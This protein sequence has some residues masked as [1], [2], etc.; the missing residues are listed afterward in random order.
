MPKGTGLERLAALSGISLQ[1][2]VRL[3]P[4]LRMKQTPPD[5]PYELKVPLGTGL[6]AAGGG[7]PGRGH[8]AQDRP[9]PAHG[10]PRGAGRRHGV[11]HRQAVRQSPPSSS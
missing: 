10:R 3:N 5:S 2:L 11:A 1:D 4:E 7:G 9:R 8:P 6:V